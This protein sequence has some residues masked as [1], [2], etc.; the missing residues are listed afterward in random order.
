MQEET[1]QISTL[2][3][4]CLPKEIWQRVLRGDHC[5]DLHEKVRIRSS[6]FKAQRNFAP[7]FS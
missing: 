3:S 4:T 5:V 7:E 2:L 6:A 1:K